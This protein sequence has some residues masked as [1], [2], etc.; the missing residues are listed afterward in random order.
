MRF[1]FVLL[2][3][4]Y[5]FIYPDLLLYGKNKYS[6]TKA[7]IPARLRISYN[8]GTVMRTKSVKLCQMHDTIV[9]IF[10]W[11][12][13]ATVVKHPWLPDISHYNIRSL[14]WPVLTWLTRYTLLTR[15]SLTVINCCS[16]YI[17]GIHM[18]NLLADADILH[19]HG[20]HLPNLAIC[21]SVT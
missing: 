12:H 5:I 13:R 16:V 17:P 11:N 15:R 8:L 9:W 6:C 2:L 4:I 1:Y 3:N 14:Y 20:S 19:L 21:Q 10:S 7:N 18:L